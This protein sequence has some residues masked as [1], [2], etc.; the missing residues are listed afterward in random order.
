[1][2]N[3]VRA[4]TGFAAAICAATGV[5]LTTAGAETPSPNALD[6]FDRT[7]E[8]TD[9]INA[10]SV[11][12]KPINETMI[13]VEAGRKTYLNVLAASCPRMVDN[14]T[15]IK[16]RLFSNKMCSGEI[17]KIVHQANST[18][19]GSCSLGQFERLAPKP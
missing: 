18:F 9:C 3:F 14:F 7:G 6:R 12:L 15:R 1:M 10:R 19:V 17:L 4:M 5:A 16:M 11:D 13:L 8:F 2:R